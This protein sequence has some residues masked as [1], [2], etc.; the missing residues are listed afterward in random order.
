LP[1]GFSWGQRLFF[2]QDGERASFTGQR[3]GEYTGEEE[4]AE[5][6]KGTSSGDAA[7]AAGESGLN[8]VLLIQ[9][10]LKQKQ[11]MRFAEG[12]AVAMMAAPEATQASDVEAAVIG[13][14]EIEGPFTEVDGLAIERDP[15][16]P[17]RV[18]V[19]F[20][21]ATSNGIVS[22]QDMEAL[23]GQIRR[24]YEE[25]DYVGS[26]VTDGPSERPTEYEGSKEEPAAWWEAFW[27]RFEGNTGLTREEARELLR[28]LGAVTRWWT[29]WPR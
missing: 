22:A 2:N 18:T 5:G 9:V 10:P 14:G 27:D 28:S 26:L 11:P 15:R 8:M 23:A 1:A 7:Q 19:Q 25:A 4:P 29:V 16:F 21:Q 12:E 13:H 20:Y 6:R 3:I 17:V 24:V